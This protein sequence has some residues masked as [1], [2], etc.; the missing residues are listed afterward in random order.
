MDRSCSG[1]ALLR[2]ENPGLRVKGF[3]IFGFGVYRGLGFRVYRGLG[4]RVYRGSGF[5]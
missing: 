4:F 5:F 3:T 2:S 1:L